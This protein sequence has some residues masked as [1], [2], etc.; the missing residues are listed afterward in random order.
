MREDYTL[1]TDTRPDGDRCE[2]FHERIDDQIGG[3]N[4]YE[5]DN[6]IP[7]YIFCIFYIP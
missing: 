4:D 6:H 7:R 5:A 3:K 2:R 1:G